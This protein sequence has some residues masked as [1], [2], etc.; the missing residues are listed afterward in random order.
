MCTSPISIKNNSVYKVGFNQPTRYEV[1]CG[2]CLECRSL[3]M[4]EWQ[5][6][7]S[8]EIKDLYDRKGVAVF[9]TFTYNNEH[10]PTIDLGD[11]VQACFDRK[12]VL[13]F[14]NQLKPCLS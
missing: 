3:A 9:L 11:I 1:P 10:L 12:A 4:V 8:Y 13:R 7:L 6:R 2:H 5:S 14:L